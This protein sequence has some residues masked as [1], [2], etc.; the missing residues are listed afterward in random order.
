MRNDRDFVDVIPLYTSFLLS[1]IAFSVCSIGR[2]GQQVKD[3]SHERLC[4]FFPWP[5]LV[6][7][8]E[9]K[10]WRPA[11]CGSMHSPTKQAGVTATIGNYVRLEPWFDSR[12]VDG[13]AS[14]LFSSCR[15][16]IRQFLGC[17][18]TGSFQIICSPSLILLPDTKLFELLKASLNYSPFCQFIVIRPTFNAFL[19]FALSKLLSW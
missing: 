6:R 18:S 3:L 12:L 4:R 14:D 9:D 7:R 17:V 15:R 1:L 10:P 2:K 11:E 8:S 16:I 19:H 5:E 13:F